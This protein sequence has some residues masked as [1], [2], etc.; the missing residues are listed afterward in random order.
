MFHIQQ[1][2]NLWPAF[3]VVSD[4]SA[5]CWFL[6]RTLTQI[7]KSISQVLLG[8]TSRLKWENSIFL[9]L[10]LT[11]NFLLLQRISLDYFYQPSNYQH[12]FINC[13]NNGEDHCLLDFT[14]AVQYMKCFMYNFNIQSL[15]L[16]R[17][18]KW[19]APNVSGFIDQLVRASH[20]YRE[21]TGSNPVEVLTFSGLYTQL[22]K[23]PSQLWWSYFTWYRKHVIKAEICERALFCSICIVT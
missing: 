15:R 8:L 3:V 10:V 11:G 23:L 22:L 7:N 20:R 4:R 16:I 18:N 6:D 17:T 12:N 2:A 13:V 9:K 1:N 21:V 14:S 5:Q 19:P